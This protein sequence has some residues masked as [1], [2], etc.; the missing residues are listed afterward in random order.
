MDSSPPGDRANRTLTTTVCVLIA[1]LA[2]VYVF[3]TFRGLDS[4]N[5]MDQAQIARELARGH[6]FRTLMIRPAA[7]HEVLVNGKDTTLTTQQDTYHPPLQSLLWAPVFKALESWWPFDVSRTVYAM[8]R[9]IA[10]MGVFWL[11]LTL[12]LTHGMARRLFD[13]TIAGVTVLSV[14]LSP[15]VWLLATGSGSRGLLLFLFTLSIY[16]L[17]LMMRRSQAGETV[18]FGLVTGIG[19]TCGLMVMTHWMAVWLVLGIAFS[20]TL[21]APRQ[22]ASLAVILGF[23]LLFMIAWAMHNQAAGAGMMGAGKAMLQS[24]L[25]PQGVAAQLRDFDNAMPPVYLE[26]L[27]HKLGVNI[28]NQMQDIYS[29]LGGVLPAMLFFLCLLHRFRRPEVQSMRWVLLIIWGTAWVG[30]AMFGLPG[31]SADDNQ[32]HCVF[33]PV[34]AMFG[35]AALAV[36]W[37]RLKPGKGGLW[38]VHGYAVIAIILTAWPMFT[39]LPSEIKSGL[40]RK[41]QLMNWPTYQPITLSFLTKWVKPEEVLASDAP[42]S[43]AWYS[44]RA[45]VWLPKDTAQFEAIRQMGE[46][47]GHHMAGIVITPLASSDD[48]AGVPF[49]GAY[50]AWA[51]WIARGPVRGLGPDLAVAIKP[52]QAFPVPQSLGSIPLADGRTIPCTTFFTDSTSRLPK[53]Q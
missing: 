51:D 31:K 14:A 34:L 45:C 46:K 13:R 1:A 28:S 37:A 21:L 23:P 22:R 17:T 24:V 43:I 7:L 33:I 6:G 8:D 32:I 16:W 5:A 49:S 4:A 44:D 53:K 20:I 50:S 35:L 25:A 9:V 29:H 11:L 47:Q 10:G 27:I 12:L 2:F 3:V 40:F 26:V 42:W 52:L 18:G 19:I 15:Q 39:G 38:H 36:F 48:I 30:M 41:N